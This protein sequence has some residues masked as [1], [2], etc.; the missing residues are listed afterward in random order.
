MKSIVGS[1]GQV[2]RFQP[3]P[4]RTRPNRSA[5]GFYRSE[6]DSPSGE[7]VLGEQAV[8]SVLRAAYKIADA[9]FDRG[10]RF[11]KRLRAAGDKATGGDGSLHALDA[12][13][14]LVFKTMMTA[15]SMLEAAAAQRGSPLK[16]LLSSQYRLLGGLIGIIPDEARA[17]PGNEQ[18]SEQAEAGTNPTGSQRTARARAASP[19]ESISIRLGKDIRGRRLVRIG[20]VHF[21]GGAAGRRFVLRFYHE[22]GACDPLDGTYS[23]DGEGR[24]RLSITTTAEAPA[25]VWRAVLCRPDGTQLGF[26]EVV[27]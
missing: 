26:I 9:Q 13:E 23:V 25:G 22:R 7:P 17:A 20:A 19:A 18:R 27:L 6:A 11:A 8:V 3:P 2:I 21:A 15:L 1:V 24:G 16:R 12:S 5:G 14:Q 4:E 10:A